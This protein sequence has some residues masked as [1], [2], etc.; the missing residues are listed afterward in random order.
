MTAKEKTIIAE[1]GSKAEKERK[2][3][4]ESTS[5]L[6]KIHKANQIGEADGIRLYTR[7]IVCKCKATV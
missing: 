4:I 5:E 7:G 1:I 3:I 6:T 2:E